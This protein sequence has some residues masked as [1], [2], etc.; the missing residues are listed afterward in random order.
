M[1]EPTIK[2]FATGLLK[3]KKPSPAFLQM[4]H[5]HYH[6]T[7]RTSTAR[8]LP[9]RLGIRVIEGSI[10]ATASLPVN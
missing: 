6:S 5:A 3:L 10:Y 8:E 4:L 9:V 7:N 1:K 2:E